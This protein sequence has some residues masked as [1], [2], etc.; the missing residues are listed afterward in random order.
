MSLFDTLI[1]QPI[2]NLLVLIYGLLPGHDFGISLILFTILVRLLMWPLV[3]KQLHQTKLIRALQPELK[4][5]KAKAKGNRQLEAQLM[6]EL[7]RERG[8]KPF[9]SF[10]LLFLQLPIFIALYRVIQIITTE[11]DKIALFTYQPIEQL[12]PIADIV[13]STT[14]QFD[15]SLLGV[16]NLTKSGISAEGIYLPIIIIA[17]LAAVLQYIQSRQITPRPDSNKKLR[18]IFRESAAGKQV[19]Q[20][21]MSTLMSNRMIVIFPFLT[22][23]IGLYL[24]GA[25]VLYFAVSSAVAVI[26]QHILLNQDVEEMEAVADLDTKDVKKPSA[27][28]KKRADDATEAVVTSSPKK[29][30]KKKRRR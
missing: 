10:G 17:A 7:Y 16:V 30:K 23:V 5:I 8:V 2:F 29:S 3:K 12:K 20:S 4:K 21:E 27:A 1:V 6:M 26:Q 18:D 19:D 11:R 15:E 14:H 24:P 28:T 25:L 22:F 9:S 13:N